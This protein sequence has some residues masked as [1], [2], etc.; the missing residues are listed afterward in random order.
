MGRLTVTDAAL[1]YPPPWTPK[2][3]VWNARSNN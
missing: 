3:P 2:L 1:Y